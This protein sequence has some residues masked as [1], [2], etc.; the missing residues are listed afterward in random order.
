MFN[1]TNKVITITFLILSIFKYSFESKE[2]KVIDLDKEDIKINIQAF[3]S[4]PGVKI[5]SK[6]ELQTLL[7]KSDVTYLHYFYTKNSSNSYVSIP[8]IVSMYNKLEYLA[9]VILTDCSED[10]E[11]IAD[12]ELCKDSKD[13]KSF[14]KLK[15]LSPPKFKINPYTKKKASY[16]EIP[17]SQSS[18]SETLI[19]NFVS[20]NISSK[21][22]KLNIDNHTQMIENPNLNKVLLFTDKPQSGLIFKGLSCYFYDRILFLEVHSSESILVNRYN[23]KKFPSLIVVQTLEEDKETE[24][25]KSSIE[26]IEYT[27]N[28]KAKDIAKFI[29][30]YA[31]SEKL[32]LNQNNRKQSIDEFNKNK[33]IQTFFKKLSGN[34]LIETFDSKYKDKRIVIFLQI[35]N[36]DMSEGLISFARK[37]NGFFNFVRINCLEDEFNI[38]ICDKFNGF[39]KFSKQNKTYLLKETNLSLPQRIKNA[40]QI[41]SFSYE[42]IS[43]EINA[44][45]TNDII[46]LSKETFQAYTFKTLNNDLKVPVIYFFEKGDIDISISLMSLDENL[47]NYITFYAYASPSIEEIKQFGLQGLPNLI[48]LGKDPLN[49]E[50]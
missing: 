43:S 19:Y 45:F 22:I 31:L 44:E 6:E 12:F 18:I 11:I 1:M 38:Q 14:P 39:N 26:V 16:S 46:G 5:S 24:K 23:I 9:D 8:F 32:Y 17:Y 34:K 49:K 47:S 30:K 7:D 28:L 29:E 36:E 2:E 13:P 33:L 35:N 25:D 10:S 42:D 40:V 48:I 50:K 20:K 21:G 3:D 15:I 37:T 41:I 4:L 27:G